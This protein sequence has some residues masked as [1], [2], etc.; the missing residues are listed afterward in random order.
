MT[1]EDI[2]RRLIAGRYRRN[3]VIP[4]YTPSHWWECDVAEITPAGLWREYEIKCSRGDFLADAKKEQ[5]R[6]GTGRWVTDDPTQ[7]YKS[8]YVREMENKHQLMADPARGPSQFWYVTPAGLIDQQEL[9]D[10]AGWMV[11]HEAPRWGTLRI[12]EVRPAPRRHRN[13]IDPKIEQHARGVIY[14]R[15]MALLMAGKDLGAAAPAT[16]NHENTRT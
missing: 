3:F 12:E 11:V 2:T 16:D 8:R 5:P 9:P 13:K 15:W 1:A 14:W 6:P 10:W 4:R 7:P